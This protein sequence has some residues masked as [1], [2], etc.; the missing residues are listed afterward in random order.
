MRKKEIKKKELEI[1]K[2]ITYEQFVKKVNQNV[3]SNSI[4]DKVS[5]L[6]SNIPTIIKSLKNL[7]P[8]GIVATIAENLDENRAKREKEALLKAMYVLYLGLF[9]IEDK[10]DQIVHDKVSVLLEDYFNF[11]RTTDY[12]KIEYF[13]NVFITGIISI[14]TSISEE[15]NIF[16]I[17]EKLD[18]IQIQILKILYEKQKERSYQSLR[19]DYTF[20]V[21]IVELNGI[22]TDITEPK[23]KQFCSDLIGKGLIEDWGIGRNDYR[24][25]EDFIINDFTKFFIKKIL[26]Y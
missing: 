19:G 1:Q 12:N 15:K 14:E 5:D 2:K 17:L 21:N 24:G 20:K 13:K 9:E 26:N 11:C 16:D 25:P 18:L 4:N 22:I 10:I 6:Y 23:L 8:F 3:E 7:E